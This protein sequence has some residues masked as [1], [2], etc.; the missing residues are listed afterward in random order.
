MFNPLDELEDRAGS[1]LSL[2]GKRRP[3]SSPSDRGVGLRRSTSKERPRQCRCLRRLRKLDQLGRCRLGLGPL[4]TPR[5]TPGPRRSKEGIGLD[6]PKARRSSSH[7][8]LPGP[9]RRTRRT[10]EALARLLATGR[11]STTE[12]GRPCYR[13]ALLKSAGCKHSQKTSQCFF[14]TGDFNTGCLTTGALNTGALKTG[15]FTT[16]CLTTGC[17]TTGCLTTGR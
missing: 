8:S 7:R 6:V 10:I 4:R 9:R 12:K 2:R 3:R 16:G 17:F 5:A 15:C 1:R 13:A 14:K 11:L